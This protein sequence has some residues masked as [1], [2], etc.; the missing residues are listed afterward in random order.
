MDEFIV[1]ISPEENS[2]NSAEIKSASGY[3]I[4]PGLLPESRSILP[5]FQVSGWQADYP[6]FLEKRVQRNPRN[7]LSHVQRTLL[8]QSMGNAEA[9]YGALIDL[10][11]VLGSRGHALRK[12]LLEQASDLLSEDQLNFLSEHVDSGLSREHIK[13]SIPDACLSKSTSGDLTIVNRAGIN[14]ADNT[15]PLALAH[16]YLKL[17][18]PSAAQLIL[19][20]ALENDPGR[21]DICKELLTLY[22]DHSWKDAFFKTYNE[23]LGRKLAVPD[24]WRQTEQFFLELQNN[25]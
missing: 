22:R 7:L 21:E 12:N 14:E 2:A 4:E 19:E 17:K 24:E 25:G 1:K 18:D 10:Y 6:R 13:S 3:V 9:T 11:L 15:D 16:Q 23:L 8:H 20:G 5:S